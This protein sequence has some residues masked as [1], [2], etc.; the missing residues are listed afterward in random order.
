MWILLGCQLCQDILCKMKCRF[1]AH[2]LYHATQEGSAENV[3]LSYLNLEG[4]AIHG[5]LP[6]TWGVVEANDTVSQSKP[7]HVLKVS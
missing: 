1:P 2:T 5:C 3:G 7:I 6:S 4:N